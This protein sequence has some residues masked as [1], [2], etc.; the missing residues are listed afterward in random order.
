MDDPVKRAPVEYVEGFLPEH[1]HVLCTLKAELAW[2][3]RGDTPRSEYYCNDYPDPYVYG[4]GRGRRLYEPRPWHPAV[5]A[6]RTALETHTSVRFEVCFLNRYDDGSDHLGWHADDH[7]GTDHTRPIAVVSF[8][9]ARE[10]WWRPNGATGEAPADCRQLLSNRSL[11][12]MPPGFQST[13]QHRIPKADRVC[14]PR[15]SLT[16]RAFLGVP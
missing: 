12:I 3:R 2:E 7:E 13:H 9:A 8:G 1:A 6:I 16:F 10:I 15:V 11:F 5:V 4:R 14:G